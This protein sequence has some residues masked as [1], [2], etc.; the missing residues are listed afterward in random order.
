VPVASGWAFFTCWAAVL[1][2]DLVADFLL[3][4]QVFLVPAGLGFF[5]GRGS[6]S[7]GFSSC[8]FSSWI[9]VSWLSALD[10]G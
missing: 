2:A 1:A 4:E 3:E 9:L 6:A 7:L 5:A 10:G 8:S